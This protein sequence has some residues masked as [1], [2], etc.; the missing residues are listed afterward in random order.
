[1]PSTFNTNGKSSYNG[2]V[3]PK[4][5]NFRF[6]VSKDDFDYGQEEIDQVHKSLMG[7]INGN[8]KVINCRRLETLEEGK[9]LLITAILPISYRNKTKYMVEFKNIQGKYISNYWMEQE[10]EDID[11]NYKIKIK[12]DKLEPTPSKHV[13]RLVFCA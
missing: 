3:F 5:E 11:K 6:C 8:I 13:E 9:E 7:G 12:C 4:I 2:N 1:M 10:L